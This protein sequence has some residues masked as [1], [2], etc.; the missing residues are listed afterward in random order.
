M[1]KGNKQQESRSVLTLSYEA[2]QRGDMVQAR[3][4]SKEVLAGKLGK[5]DEKAAAE[6]ARLLST[7]G[8]VVAENPNAVANELISRTVVPPRPYLML[9][10]VAA[11]FV[12]L[13]ILAAW[14]Y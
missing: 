2:F 6:L 3:A 1:A 7:E 8:A 5:D 9:L 11:A 4:L 14:R 10:A 12:G 13:V